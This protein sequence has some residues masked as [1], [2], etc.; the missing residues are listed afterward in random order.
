MLLFL[1]LL[2]D[3]MLCFNQA[4]TSNKGT[5]V[6]LNEI[7]VFGNNPNALFL[8]AQGFS[9]LSDGS[10]VVSDKLD[11]KI[12]KFDPRGNLI[13]ESGK[14]GKNQGEFHAGPGS[15]DSYGEVIAVADFASPRVQVFS[16]DLKHRS[17]FFARGAIFDLKFDSRGNLWLGTVRLHTDKGGALLRCDLTGKILQEIS[18]HNTR[19]DMFEDIFS[20]SITPSGN[21]I[22]AYLVQNKIEVWNTNGEFQFEFSVP[23]LP[24]KPQKHVLSEGGLFS[25]R[26]TVPEGKIFW[27]V[28]TDKKDNIFLLAADYTDTPN[29]DVY[30]FSPSGKF[31]TRFILPEPSHYIRIDFQNNMFTIENNRTLVR[32]GELRYK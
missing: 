11:Y 18:L 14:R 12:K 4:E 9:V 5:T 1:Y 6:T 26:L 20:F 13:I 7:Q 32:K 22:I 31:I 8:S 21:I 2:I 17:T 27:C 23:G 19:G 25:K 29:R 16:S 15:I 24:P 10:L 28:T 3:L 30:V